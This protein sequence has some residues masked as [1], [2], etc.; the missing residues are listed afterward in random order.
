LLVVVVVV[1]VV[2]VLLL[3]LRG[4]TLLPPAGLFEAR[5]RANA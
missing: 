5:K 4:P 1:V 2:V 3:V